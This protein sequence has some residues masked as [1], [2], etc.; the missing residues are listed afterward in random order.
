MIRERES[1]ER[2]EDGKIYKIFNAFHGSVIKNNVK[3]STLRTSTLQ[4]V[5]ES[6]IFK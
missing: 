1:Y 3:T 5:N 4:H 2:F 6:T